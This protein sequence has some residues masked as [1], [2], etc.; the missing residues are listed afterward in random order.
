MKKSFIIILLLAALPALALGGCGE[1]AVSAEPPDLT[2]N[3]IQ[4]GIEDTPF[5][6]VATIT[7]DTI[8]CWWHVVDGDEEHL[9]WSGTFTPPEDGK[10]PYAWTSENDLEKALTSSWALRDE[11]KTFTYE[12][13]KLSYI[14]NMGH[15]R[16]T[17]ALERVT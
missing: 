7:D 16:M 10:E 14:V 8:E 2:G 3:W 5:Y 6:Q 1:T 17:Y 13:G 11:I 12:K 15:L 4:A 9:Y